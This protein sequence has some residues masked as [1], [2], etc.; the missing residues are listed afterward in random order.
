MTLNPLYQSAREGGSPCWSTDEMAIMMAIMVP[1]PYTIAEARNHLTRLVREVE[2][3]RTVGLTRRGKLVA[4]VVSG[5]EFNRLHG[6]T[7]GLRTALR[8]FLK[9]RPQGGVLSAR[10]VAAL[11]DR[12]PGRKV[13]W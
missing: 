1:Y 13:S 8:A 6:G 2:G 7:G 12:S 3:G 11:R 10:G 4:V 5:P 9:E